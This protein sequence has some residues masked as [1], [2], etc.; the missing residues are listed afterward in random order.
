MSSAILW[1]F[2][3]S[4]CRGAG[5]CCAKARATPVGSSD[6]AAG[7]PRSGASRRRSPRQRQPTS[8]LDLDFPRAPAAGRIQTS[9]FIDFNGGRDDVAI[10]A[11][12]RKDSSTFG[13]S[14]I[15]DGADGAGWAEL[16]SNGAEYPYLAF[17]AF[18]RGDAP[19][20]F[21]FTDWDY[22]GY[23]L[24]SAGDVD[25]DSVEDY[26]TGSPTDPENEGNIGIGGD[27]L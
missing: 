14:W 3:P 15:F 22:Y 23:S 12:E 10:S 2:S 18:G 27:G 4:P 21:G 19:R 26:I 20:L 5:D 13:R 24:H 6:G 11:H 1:P 8:A 17:A 25:D 9:L 16:D 7:S